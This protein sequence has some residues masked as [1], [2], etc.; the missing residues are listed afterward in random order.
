MQVARVL[1][2][3]ALPEA[4]ETARDLRALGHEP[5]VAPLRELVP[6]DTPWP[7]MRPDALIA[8]SR[9]AFAPPLP[10]M[11]E[12]YRLPI[13][14]VGE[15]TGEAA[16]EAG[17]TD[18]RIGGGD[19]AALA[20]H[21]IAES[22]AGARLLYLA[23]EP[24]RPELEADLAAAGMRVTPLLRYRM[25][26][27][28]TLPDLARAALVAGALDAVLHFSGETAKTFA[29]LVAAAGL[30]PAVYSLRHFCLSPAIATGLRQAFAQAPNLGLIVAEEPTARSLLAK[31]QME[32]I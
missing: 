6:V 3:R 27:G 7:E 21:I 20:R 18:I 8:T 22:R 9:H 25:I 16:R 4:E 32:F 1:V 26:A 31:L 5:I 14:V 24:H 19:A 23:G 2:T 10:E 28:G 15:R 13:H 11:A 12:W 30:G 17:F 29:D